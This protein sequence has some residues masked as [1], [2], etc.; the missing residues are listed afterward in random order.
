[1]S[2]F[3]RVELEIRDRESLIHALMDMGYKD[4]RGRG[5]V[6]GYQGAEE[7]A[8]LVVFQDHGYDI[9]VVDRGDHME[10]VAD[11]IGVEGGE[12]AFMGRLRQ[13]YAE[14]VIQKTLRKRGNRVTERRTLPNG[15]IVLKVRIPEEAEFVLPREGEVSVEGLGFEG[16]QCVDATTPFEAALGKVQGERELKPEFAGQ[17]APSSSAASRRRRKEERIQL[18]R[19]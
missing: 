7:I 17:D 1:M 10:I 16:E 5:R 8:D 13:A 18:D 14:R 2:H 4:I 9:G 15:D 6:R 19:S 3:T 11:W 12:D